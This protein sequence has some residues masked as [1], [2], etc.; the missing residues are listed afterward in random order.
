ML[1]FQENMKEHSLRFNLDGWPDYICQVICD[2]FHQG[3]AKYQ[4][5]REI[6]ASS[7]NRET[8]YQKLLNVGGGAYEDRIK[9]LKAEHKRLRDGGTFGKVYDAGNGV[10]K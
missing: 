2:I 9:T 8:V 4:L 6:L 10:F 1:L 7:S 3:R 5:V